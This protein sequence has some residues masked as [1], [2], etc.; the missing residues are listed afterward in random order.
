MTLQEQQTQPAGDE[1]WNI[2]R[3]QQLKNQTKAKN[4]YIIKFINMI[5]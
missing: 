5:F 1:W 3:E 4:P 2:L